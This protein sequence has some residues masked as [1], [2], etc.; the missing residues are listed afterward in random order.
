MKRASP[1]RAATAAGAPAPRGH[2]IHGYREDQCGREAARD[3]GLPFV[4]LDQIVKARAG[5]RSPRSSRS[6]ARTDSGRWS[7][8]PWTMPRVSRGRSS[9]PGVGRSWIPSGFAE[10]ADGS[11]VAVLTADPGELAGRLNG[12]GG[13]PL[14]AGDPGQGASRSSFA[15]AGRRTPPPASPWTPRGSRRRPPPGRCAYLRTPERCRGQ[16]AT[17]YARP[18]RRSCGP[19]DR[20]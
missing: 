16:M 20:S 17:R 12:A 14:L 4:D 7:A 5:I 15:T 8:G 11:I 2:G 18:G 13:R 10:L 19:T 3:L 9:P 1:S 6:A